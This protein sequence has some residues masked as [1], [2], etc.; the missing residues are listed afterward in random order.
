MIQSRKYDIAIKTILYI[1]GFF[2]VWE[3]IRP[4]SQL[5]ETNNI[6]V[7]ILFMAIGFALH[8]FKIPPLSRFVILGIFILIVIHY[9]YYEVSLFELSWFFDFVGKIAG[10]IALLFHGEFL[11]ISFEFQTLLFFI[12]LWLITYL[13][14]YWISV[15]KSILLFFIATVVIVSV[16][17]TFTEY[18]GRYAIIRLVIIGFSMLGSLALFRLAAQEKMPI[19]VPSLRKWIIPLVLMIAFSSYIGLAAPKL[20]PQWPDPVPFITSY[21][22]SATGGGGTNRIGYGVDDSSLGGGF[23]NDDTVVFQAETSAGHYWKVENKDFY[24]GKGWV[25]ADNAGSYEEFA[26][27]EKVGISLYPP[28]VK[29]TD[30]KAYVNIE[31]PYNHVPYPGPGSVTEISS[32]T[33]E[34][35]RYHGHND[36]V[37]SHNNEGNFIKLKAFELSYSLP[38]FDINQLKEVGR[39]EGNQLNPE[40]LNRYTQIP[41]GFPDRIRELAQT[42]TA[43]ETNWYDQ[44]KAIENHFDGGEFVYDQVDIPYPGD[45]EDYVDQFLFETKRGYC[46]NFSTSMVMLLRSIDIPA[47]W[48]KG[49]TEGD[50][51]TRDGERVYEVTNNN[52]HSWVE[53]YFPNAGWVPFEPTKGFSNNTEFYSSTETDPTETPEPGTEQEEPA[54]QQ[55]TPTKPEQA[56]EKQTAESAINQ[57]SWLNENWKALIAITAGILLIGLLIFKLRGRWLPYLLIAFYKRKNDHDT[58]SKAYMTLLKQLRRKGL[59]RPGDQT[60][61]DYADYVDSYFY[62]GEMGKI[63]RNYELYIYRGDHPSADWEHNQ[64][65][66]ENLIKKTIA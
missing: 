19:T 3:W 44:V 64:K 24:T 30:S 38:S 47:R 16:L 39:T 23:E 50:Q 58:F 42:I 60:L 61:R 49:Y 41:T 5:T 52:A 28:G 7:F 54:A 6:E 11:K 62:S 22:D 46:D 63:T 1:F 55:E 53:V 45:A 57:E 43:E 17:D 40:F 65:L 37:T 2:L 25:T 12:L 15:K 32:P 31:L 14:H 9:L 18:E 48:V 26:D 4:V 20:D 33:G 10:D 35:Y 29:T 13:L 66:W 36:R 21:S 8:L 51:V 27:A 59:K 34:L 56:T